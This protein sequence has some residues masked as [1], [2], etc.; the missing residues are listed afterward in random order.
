MN[1]NTQPQDDQ[2]VPVPAPVPETPATDEGATAPA[3]EET[4][5]A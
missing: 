4:P 5:A 1:E 3:P 2:A